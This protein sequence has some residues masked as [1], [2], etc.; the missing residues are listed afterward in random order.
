MTAI[1]TAGVRPSDTAT[2]SASTNLFQPGVSVTKTC[3]PDPVVVGG[4][5]TCT[6]VVTNTSSDDAPGLINGTIVD[7]LTGDLLDAANTAVDSSNCTAALRD[8]RH[9]A[10]SSRRGR[11]WPT[12]PNPLV[13]MVT[14]HYNPQGFPNDITD[15]ATDSVDV[16]APADITSR[17]RP[18]RSPRWAT[19]SPTRSGSATR[20]DITVNRDSVTDSLLGNITAFVPGHVGAGRSVRRSSWS[21][22]WQAG[23]P[24]PLVNT[25][26]ATYSSGRTSDTATA[27]ASTNLFQPGVSVTK[28]CTPDPVDVGGVVTCTIVVT[29]TSSED[30]P[31]L[32]NGTI[33]DT[34]TGNLLD[35][36]NTAVDSS[37]C[38]A[39]PADRWERA[40][41]SR[42][43]RCWRPTPTR[44][45][46]RSRCTTTRRG[47]PT[48][49][50]TRLRTA[51]P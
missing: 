25:V 20:R 30:S 26:T 2:A 47:S 33:V 35:A 32:I 18:M 17:R 15:T 27:S 46:T 1:Y 38:T 13:N 39:D 11:C 19:R 41:S 44:S 21:G 42:R 31:A 4:V 49:S 45:S 51:S 23:D 28:S 24:D 40:R 10:R 36:A 50:P 48:T 29:N 12:D 5:V 43:G 7:T 22:R 9:A 6:I 16:M 34:L 8:R 14:V 3:T 37:N